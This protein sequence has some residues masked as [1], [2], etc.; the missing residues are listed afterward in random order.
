MLGPRTIPRVVVAAATGTAAVLLVSSIAYL[1]AQSDAW[2]PPYRMLLTSDRALAFVLAAD[3]KLSYVPGEVLVKFKPG[4]G[5]EG[6]ERAL[7]ALRSRPT[8]NRL[9]W[10]GDVA[11]WKDPSEWNATILAA[12]L[13]A[14]PEVAY[15]E[16]NYLAR[17]YAAPNDPGFAQRQWNLTALDMPKAWD[18]NPG[19]ADTITVA[20]V[21]TGITTAPGRSCSRPGTARRLRTWS[22]RTA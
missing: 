20:V 1:S 18:I 5:A 9:R 6:Q 12:Q 10:V 19:A 21:D 15:A 8:P 7:R 4:V 16:P 13:A 3:R 17:A 22:C 2:N 11:V 14:Q